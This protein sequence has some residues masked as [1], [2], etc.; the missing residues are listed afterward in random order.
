MRALVVLF[1]LLGTSSSFAQRIC[2]NPSNI[3]SFEVLN[4]ESLIVQEF[5]G[6]KYKLELARF[7]EG[8]RETQEIRFK[9]FSRGIV[10]DRDDLI[11]FYPF[12]KR[13]AS[14]CRI[15]KITQAR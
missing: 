3:W 15:S 14:Y 2:F 8:L 5:G 9:T 11:V 10:C 12:N 7:C 13:P 6:G 4:D 1:I